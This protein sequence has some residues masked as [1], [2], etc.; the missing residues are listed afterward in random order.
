MSPTTIRATVADKQKYKNVADYRAGTIKCF[1]TRKNV[2]LRMKKKLLI[3]ISD[4]K[5]REMM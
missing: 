4:S 2:L 5:L 3:W 1:R